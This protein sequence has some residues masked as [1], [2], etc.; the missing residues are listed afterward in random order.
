MNVN[1]VFVYGTLKKGQPN[2]YYMAKCQ[3]AKYLGSAETRDRFPL[4]IGDWNLPMMVDAISAG[5][6]V[7]GEV[8]TV[9]YEDLAALDEFEDCPELYFR[10]EI[11]ILL[12]DSKT[13][14]SQL[15]FESL[16][17]RLI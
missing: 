2:N 7:K 13:L 5:N 10:K 9:N 16:Y 15:I 11:D 3:S 12:E 6:N 4:V 14:F 17:V 1:N 8:Y